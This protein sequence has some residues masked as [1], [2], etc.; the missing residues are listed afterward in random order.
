MKVVN[1]MGCEILRVETPHP[2]F[3][4]VMGDID[5][6]FHVGFLGDGNNLID[7]DVSL[8]RYSVINK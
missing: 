6:E 3:K 2:F 8:I 1:D 5:W 7:V 4:V